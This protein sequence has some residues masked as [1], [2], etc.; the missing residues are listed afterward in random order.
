MPQSLGYSQ[1][2][3]GTIPI[4]V[5]PDWSKL[6]HVH[7]DVSSIALGVVLMQLSKG[8][9]DHLVYYDSCKFFDV[10]KNYT[11]IEGKGLTMVCAL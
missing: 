5:F 4:L 2:E 10:E 9:I 7:V 1:R 6:F 11:T 3:I 8:N